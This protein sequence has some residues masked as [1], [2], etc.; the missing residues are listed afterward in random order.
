MVAGVSEQVRS[1]GPWSLGL[2]GGGGSIRRVSLNLFLPL[3]G[4]PN[5]SL[6]FPEYPSIS[7]LSSCSSW[8]SHDCP[9]LL[10]KLSTVA[11]GVKSDECW[12]VTESGC[13]AWTVIRLFSFGTC[14]GG[15]LRDG[16]VTRQITAELPRSSL[17]D[18]SQRRYLSMSNLGTYI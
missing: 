4:S 9:S 8:I 3:P 7:S 18:T 17:C 5:H 12:L 11:G 16:G 2:P 6:R 10:M 14:R 15:V 13:I 1:L